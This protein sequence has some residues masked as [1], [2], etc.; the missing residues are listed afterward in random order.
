MVRHD[1]MG[2]ICLK[3]GAGEKRCMAVDRLAEAPG[4]F[5]FSKHFRIACEKPGNVHEFA[6]AENV[7]ICEKAF[8]G[9][10]IE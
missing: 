6:K 10:G 8:N 3:V 9:F 2:G 1:A 7:G 5:D 4:C